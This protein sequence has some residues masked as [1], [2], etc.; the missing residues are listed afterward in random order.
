MPTVSRSSVDQVY[1]NEGSWTTV[2]SQLRT[3]FSSGN[4]IYASHLSYLRDRMNEMIGHYH[5]FDLDA[6]QLATYGSGYGDN[7]GA[8]DRN[9]YYEYN[10][11][12]D[13]MYNIPTE[14]AT[15]SAGTTIP[16]SDHNSLANRSRSMTNHEHLFSDRTSA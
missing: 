11:P 3:Y 9:N 7:P 1:T 16:A 10:D 14:S 5:V 6:Y 4:I 12:T 2:I 13:A 15:Y 8:G